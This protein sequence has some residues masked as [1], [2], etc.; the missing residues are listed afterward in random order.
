MATAIGAGDEASIAV[1]V[2]TEAKGQSRRDLRRRGLE[3][4]DFPEAPED[5]LEPVFHTRADLKPKPPCASVLK[6]V[7]VAV[8]DNPRDALLCMARADILVTSHSSLGWAAAVLNEG[9][10]LHP[11]SSGGSTM[12]WDLRDQYLDWAENWFPTSAVQ[13][14]PEALRSAFL[15]GRAAR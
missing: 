9:L 6:E 12:H 11:D 4:F 2:H 3:G 7:H 15:R 8:N 14:R 5:D 1:H 13:R 10:V